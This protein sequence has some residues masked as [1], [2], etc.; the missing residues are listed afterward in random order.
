MTKRL[1]IIRTEFMFQTVKI[2]ALENEFIQHK[3]NNRFEFGW[4]IN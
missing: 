2:L 1:K 3:N 4:L